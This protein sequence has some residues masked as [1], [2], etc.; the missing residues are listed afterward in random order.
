MLAPPPLPLTWPTTKASRPHSQLHRVD[1]FSFTISAA[2]TLVPAITRHLPV[3]SPTS[4][5]RP[6]PRARSSC[7]LEDQKRGCSNP[8]GPHLNQRD[9]PAVP[10]PLSPLHHR[11]LPQGLCT[12]HF[13][14]QPSF[15]SHPCGLLTLSGLCLGVTFLRQD[16]ADRLATNSGASAPPPLPAPAASTASAVWRAPRGSSLHQAQPA[17]GATRGREQAGGPEWPDVPAQGVSLPSRSLA[18]AESAGRLPRPGC[19]LLLAC[20][21]MLPSHTACAGGGGLGAWRQEV[22]C[23]WIPRNPMDLPS[24]PLAC[25]A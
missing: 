5:N 21:H 4:P 20:G 16:T 23:G 12:C 8:S 15:L 18:M 24:R 22:S 13:C 19:L 6:P 1:P 14:L 17:L 7:R 10:W 2:G 11:L 3:D 9:S 25:P